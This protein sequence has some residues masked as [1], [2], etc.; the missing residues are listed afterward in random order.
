MCGD[1]LILPFLLLL[2]GVPLVGVPL[3]LV[4]FTPTLRVLSDGYKGRGYIIAFNLLL[5]WTLIGWFIA[6]RW[7][8]S[9]DAK[10]TPRHR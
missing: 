1:G 4:Y 6:M 3:L 9:K 8:E 2:Y 7:A 10:V 5:G